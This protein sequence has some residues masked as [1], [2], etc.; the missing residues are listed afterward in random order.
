MG[1]SGRTVRP[2]PWGECPVLRRIRRRVEAA[3]G[4]QFN[5]VLCN[6]YRTGED[7][8]GWHADNES[9]YGPTPTIAT[10]SLGAA[11]GFDLRENATP[12]RKLRIELQPGSLL[13]MSGDTQQRWQHSVPRRKALREERINLTFRQI[14]DETGG[15]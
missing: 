14:Q 5:T 10:V 12:N 8:V 11:R 9:V 6:L 13:V 1:Y 7:T 3:V 15:K 2:R 4:M